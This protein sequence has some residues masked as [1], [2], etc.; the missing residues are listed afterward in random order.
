[1]IETFRAAGDVDGVADGA[2][3]AATVWLLESVGVVADEPAAAAFWLEGGALELASEAAFETAA[4]DAADV[5]ADAAAEAVEVPPDVEDQPA[6]AAF[7]LAGGAL[8]V[9]PDPAARNVAE[10]PASDVAAAADV[11][12]Q[13]AVAAFRFEG[14]ALAAAAEGTS[15]A[16]SGVAASEAASEVAASE[17]AS[18]VAASEAASEVAASEAAS[19]VEASD[20]AVAD[21]A[22]AGHV[23]DQPALTASWCEGGVLDAAADGAGE[24][25]LDGTAAVAVGFWFEGRAAESAVGVARVGGVGGVSVVGSQPGKWA[26][27][28][29]VVGGG[30]SG[31]GCLGGARSMGWAWVWVSRW[32]ASAWMGRLVKR[33]AGKGVGSAAAWWVRVARACRSVVDGAEWR[34]ASVRTGRPSA[35]KRTFWGVMAPWVRPEVWRWARASASGARRV[36]SSP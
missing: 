26:G 32:W 7:W 21:V 12:D 6:V 8:D 10:E 16:A 31:V 17:A 4:R 2:E 33:A 22:V 19:D 18:E 13:P 3:G 5:A 23:G 20:V 28:G 15:E 9:A 1:V 25:A 36:I 35:S 30:G 34:V 27:G 29:A 24:A 11:A 14:G